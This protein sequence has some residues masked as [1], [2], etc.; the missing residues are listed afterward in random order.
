[1]SV[2]RRLKPDNVFLVVKG[3]DQEVAR[4]LLAQ[5][6]HAYRETGVAVYMERMVFINNLMPLLKPH[7][8][9]TPEEAL[10]AERKVDE[11]VVRRLPLAP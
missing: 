1:M 10:A 3:L 11:M 6:D 8:E 2:V 4:R 9:Q 7:C 5:Y